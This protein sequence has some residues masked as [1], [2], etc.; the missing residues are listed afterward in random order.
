[1]AKPENKIEK[2]E[3]TEDNGC[4]YPHHKLWCITIMA[5]AIIVLAWLPTAGQMWSKVVVTILAVLIFARSM[6]INCCK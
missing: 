1:M 3:K 2:A 6:M 5:I 4:K